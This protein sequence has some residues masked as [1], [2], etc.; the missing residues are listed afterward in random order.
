MEVHSFSSHFTFFHHRNDTDGEGLTSQFKR[1]SGGETPFHPGSPSGNEA[2]S[3]A[4]D[5]LSSQQ[6]SLFSL[7]CAWCG[8]LL[9]SYHPQRLVL[10]GRHPRK[11][12][13][14]SQLNLTA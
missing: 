8:R 9:L 6:N 3:L 4:K 1:I 10:G 12:A 13:A 5:L 7:P 11:A 2:N 14:S